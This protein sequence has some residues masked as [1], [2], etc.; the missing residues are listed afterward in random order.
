MAENA[1]SMPEW[2]AIPGFPEYQVSDDGRIRR[3]A[4]MSNGRTYNLWKELKPG[5]A[6]GYLT[7][8]LC[9]RGVVTQM[10][11]HKI[12]ATTFIGPKPSAQHLVAHWDG[13]RRNNRVENLRWATVAENCADRERHGNTAKGERQGSAVLTADAIRHIRAALADPEKRISGAALARL[14]GVGQS[15]ISRIKHRETWVHID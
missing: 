3:A 12:V 11:V 10:G 13:N 7:V 14:Y 2:R 9:V 5:L 4:P 6:S 1:G 8:R 15:Q